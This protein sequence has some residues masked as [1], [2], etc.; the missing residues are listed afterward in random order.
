MFAKTIFD[1]GMFGPFPVAVTS[2]SIAAEC[3][4][5]AASPRHV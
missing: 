4:D 1:F 3:V 5:P 2:N